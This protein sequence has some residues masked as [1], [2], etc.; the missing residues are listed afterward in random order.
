MEVGKF[1]VKTTFYGEFRL[2][3]YFVVHF[4]QTYL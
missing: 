2:L 3:P 4:V 1:F